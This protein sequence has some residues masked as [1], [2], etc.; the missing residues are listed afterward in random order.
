MTD[1]P[2]QDLSRFRQPANFRG[3]SAAVVQLW[4]LVQGTLFAWSPQFLYGWRN[5]LLRLFGARIGVG[6]I[7]RPSARITYPWKL[8]IGDHSWIGDYAELYTLGPITIGSN[9]VVS[10]YSY[11][12][13]GSHDMGSPAFDIFAKPI[14]VED[15]AWVAAGVFVHPGVTVGKGAV[16]A[17]RSVVTRDVPPGR[18][19]GGHPAVDMGPR[20][21][22]P[23]ARSTQGR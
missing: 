23:S 21:T 11:L 13:T 3:R 8:A 2:V 9:A 14:V 18:L 17:S 20:R 1:G 19:H 7:I 12:C 5:G 22:T 16:V 6:V 4:W 15:E 10:Q